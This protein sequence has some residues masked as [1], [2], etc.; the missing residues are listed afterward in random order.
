MI[1][2]NHVQQLKKSLKNEN[3]GFCDPNN[4]FWFYSTRNILKGEQLFLNYGFMYW[5]NN[6]YKNLNIV[7]T[8]KLDFN[9]IK[10]N[11]LNMMRNYSVNLEK[12]TKI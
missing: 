3:V 8:Y 2:K 6:K 1:L 5:L 7:S 11:N 10:Y 12:N 4:Y 9:T